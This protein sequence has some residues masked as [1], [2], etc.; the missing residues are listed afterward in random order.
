[1]SPVYIYLTVIISL[2]SII[3]ILY[4]PYGESFVNSYDLPRIIWSY[5]EG[6]DIPKIIQLSHARVKQKLPDWDVKLLNQTTVKSYLDM[7]NVPANY[8]SLS[9]QHKADWIRAALL[10]A[11]GG[12]WLDAA[13]IVNDGSA[14]NKLL[15]ESIE[16]HSEFTGF[17]LGGD[18]YIENWFMMAPKNS[19]VIN[20]IYDEFSRAITL[21]FSN[22]KDELAGET[23][24]QINPRIYANGT[25]LTQHSC[26][27][28]VVQAR[29][30]RTPRMVLKPSEE[31]MFKL[32]TDCNWNFECFLRKVLQPETY[33]IPY[34]KLR[35]VEQQF[36]YERYFSEGFIP[37]DRVGWA[38]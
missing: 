3:Y 5:W 35:S 21:G 17:T 31:S 36:D 37:A 13:I 8:E 10:R 25:Y 26:I 27:Q 38:N 33:K 7:T 11:H 19:E 9:V 1:M 34:L 32:Q 18:S 15:K 20:K 28:A 6:D 14:L 16:A 24:I 22:Y 29:L 4:T 23:H 2:I 30:G 12:V